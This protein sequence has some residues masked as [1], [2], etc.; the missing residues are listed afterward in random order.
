[1]IFGYKQYDINGNLLVN[2]F[3]Q[4]IL[5]QSK[6]ISQECCLFLGGKS[7]FH[8]FKDSNN[9]VINSGYVCCKTQGVKK[10]MIHK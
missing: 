9:N 2:Y 4:P 10:N 3:G 1:M 5:N 7:F 8:E 6:Y